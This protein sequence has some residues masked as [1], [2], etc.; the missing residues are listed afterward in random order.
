MI[1]LT[2]DTHIPLDISKLNTTRFPGQNTLT[3]DDYVII[4]GDFGLYWHKDKEYEYWLNWLKQ[5]KFTILWLDGNHE[6]HE[7]IDSFPV[8]YWNG[9]RVHQTEDNIIHLMRGEVYN[10]DGITF[11]TCGGGTS[12]DR[13]ERVEGISWWARENI[14][15]AEQLNAI[16]NL[17]KHNNSVDYILTHSICPEIVS[18][19]F[20]INDTLGIGTTERFLS[21]VLKTVKFKKWYFGHWHI[22]MNYSKFQC[23]YNDVVVL[24]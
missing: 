14:S 18:E 23:L 2:G 10:I 24:V 5:K 21:N 12:I 13:L 8:T 7:W 4:L 9:G 6:N 19:M 3:R 15:Y 22:D 1:Y 20:H 11:F 17:K 16:D